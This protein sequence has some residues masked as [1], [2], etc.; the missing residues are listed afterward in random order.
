[1]MMNGK[2]FGRKRS[3]PNSK[4][5]SWHYPAGTDEIHEEMSV[6]IAG[7]RGRDLNLGTPEYKA[8]VL[9]TRPQRSPSIVG[10]QGHFETHFHISC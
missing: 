10:E 2:G 1:M 9:T 4:V 6:R 7:R 8:G 3:W 5:L